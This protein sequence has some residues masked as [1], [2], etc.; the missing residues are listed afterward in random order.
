MAMAMRNVSMCGA[1][2]HAH[3]AEQV[4]EGVLRLG[5]ARDR[6]GRDEDVL[7]EGVGRRGLDDDA[8]EDGEDSR[9]EEAHAVPRGVGEVVKQRGTLHAHI[10]VERDGQAREQRLQHGA[11]NDRLCQ[12]RGHRHDAQQPH[13]HRCTRFGGGRRD[14][15][16]ERARDVCVEQPL[17]SGSAPSARLGK[18]DHRLGG[19]LPAAALAAG[20]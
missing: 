3:L 13:R 18:H 20:E 1:H 11:T 17:R 9:V 12:H 7:L 16:R 14:E 6:R 15:A 19:R 5:E 10:R 4:G 8:S 2:G